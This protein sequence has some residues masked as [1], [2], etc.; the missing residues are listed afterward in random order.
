M[1]HCKCYHQQIKKM[2]R[3]RDIIGC[4]FKFYK[5]TKQKLNR[6]AAKKTMA[7]L[8]DLLEYPTSTDYILLVSHIRHVWAIARM[9][10]QMSFL[11][12]KFSV[13]KILQTV[14]FKSQIM[15][16]NVL[17]ANECFSAKKL[18]F[19]VAFL[20][21]E[22]N[23]NLFHDWRESWLSTHTSRFQLKIKGI[24]QLKGIFCMTMTKSIN[25]IQQRNG[26]T[27][28]RFLHNLDRT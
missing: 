23:Q 13:K 22:L 26:L 7:K 4:H 11:T 27:N 28:N 14:F 2:V 18:T 1:A 24:S 3:H 9:A 15:C 8:K 5:R 25:P 12:K 17:M 21:P 20:Q 6:E 19:R 10:R 16:Q